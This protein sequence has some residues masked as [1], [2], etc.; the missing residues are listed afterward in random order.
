MTDS[1]E[2]VY[3]SNITINNSYFINLIGYSGGGIYSFGYVVANIS[4]SV[5]YNNSVYY[6]SATSDSTSGKGGA[7]YFECYHQNCYMNLTNGSSFLSNY[8][9]Q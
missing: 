6:N 2:G 7:I 8:A 9:A 5:F 4:N 1:L 3:P